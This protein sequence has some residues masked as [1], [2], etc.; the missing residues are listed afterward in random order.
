MKKIL[1]VFIALMAIL[2][3][4]CGSKPAEKPAAPA[5]PA[6]APAPAAPAAAA[7]EAPAFVQDPAA[8]PASDYSGDEKFLSANDLKTWTLM[9]RKDLDDGFYIT[10]NAEK[11]VVI[12]AQGSEVL[13]AAD[14]QVFDKR[15]S[16]GG[17]GNA[18][19]R[20]VYFTADKPGK[21]YIYLMSSSK[22]EART[23]LVSQKTEDGIVPVG[24]VIAPIYDRKSVAIGVVDIPDAGEY[25]VAS[26]KSGI[27]VYE[28]LLR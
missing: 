4:A 10:A 3:V 15:I 23:L 16:L 8:I 14:G 28:I 1:V 6:A 18:D 20:S 17:S 11:N 12:Q 5:A 21:A 13:T 22:T 2:C 9:D 27:Y 24:Q 7:V 19:F 26:K 25:Y